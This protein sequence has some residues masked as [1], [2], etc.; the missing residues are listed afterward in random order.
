MSG[1]RFCGIIE[2][3]VVYRSAVRMNPNSAEE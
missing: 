2:L 3:P 1:L